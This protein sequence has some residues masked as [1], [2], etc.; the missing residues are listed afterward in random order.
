MALR[1]HSLL[2]ALFLGVGL[3]ST[4]ARAETA[5]P[6]P[7]PPPP[8]PA[9]P[10]PASPQAAAAGGPA[11]VISLSGKV[12]DYNRD[13]LFRRFDKARKLGAKTVILQ[14][15]TYGGLV[16][17]GLDISRFLKRQN[18][19]HTIALR[20]GQGHLGRRDDRRRLQRDRD[21]A[22]P[23]RWATAPRSR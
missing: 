14:I 21:G 19:I 4:P 20:Q 3:I 8:P 2:A 11:A 18:D 1:L 16:T 13:A 15:D 7:P 12:D 5:P 23:P 22:R 9:S 6:V 17:S 10:A